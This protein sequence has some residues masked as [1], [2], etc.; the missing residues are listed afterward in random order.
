M[1]LRFQTCLSVSLL[2]MYLSNWSLDFFYFRHDRRDLWHDSFCQ[3]MAA[4]LCAKTNKN[5]PK[6]GFI[7]LFLTKI[8]IWVFLLRICDKKWSGSRII[9]FSH[10]SLTLIFSDLAYPY[11]QEIL[12]TDLHPGW[13]WF[14]DVG[15]IIN[16]YYCSI[17]TEN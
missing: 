12:K 17:F 8:V 1:N 4:F 5:G 10:I 7:L 3:K 2:K 14:I 11:F 6:G 15:F 16:I 13:C 9:S